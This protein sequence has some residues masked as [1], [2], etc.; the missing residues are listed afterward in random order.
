MQGHISKEISLKCRLTLN[1]RS[2]IAKVQ[3]MLKGQELQIIEKKKIIH[4]SMKQK[5]KNKMYI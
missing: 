1:G 4:F 3:G 5:R 2:Q